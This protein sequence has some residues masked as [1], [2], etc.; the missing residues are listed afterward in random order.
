MKKIIL[1]FFIFFNVYLVAQADVMPYYVNSLRRGGIGYTKVQSPLV[2]RREPKI[3][4]EILETLNFNYKIEETTCEKN[5]ERCFIDEVFSS[6]SKSKKL[7]F[8]TTLDSIDG[9]NLVCF[10][11]NEM[12]VCGWV[13]EE[14]NKFYTLAEFFDTFGKKY[15]IYLFK[16]LQKA[17]K[18]LYAAPIK[19]TNST[20]SLEMPKSI[21]PWLIRGNWILVKAIDFQGQ[22]KTGWLNFRGSDGKLKV[23]VKF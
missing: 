17:D 19:Q 10:N 23:F 6:Y 22:A 21:T 8:M 12:P 16:D 4:G 5:K 20:G 7:A 13:E 9:W 11:Q 14:K 18:I 15:G 1:S 3:D 2:M